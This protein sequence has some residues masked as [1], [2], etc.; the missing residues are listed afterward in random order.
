M[1]DIKIGKNILNEKSDILKDYFDDLKDLSTISPNEELDLAR[2]ARNGDEYARKLLNELNNNSIIL[3]KLK[4][5]R[6]KL[7]KINESS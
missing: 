3:E 5:I 2:R 6:E 7:C 1:K 4:E